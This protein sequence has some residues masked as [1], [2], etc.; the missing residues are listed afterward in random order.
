M[1]KPPPSPRQTTIMRG[2]LRLLPFLLL[3]IIII[4][5]TTQVHADSDGGGAAGLISPL[6]R[7]D[8][9]GRLPQSEAAARAVAK[10]G[11]VIA[12]A[13]AEAVLLVAPWCVL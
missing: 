13:A 1:S 7:F 12:I 11:S 2:P 8:A 9:Q 5:T 6:T 3:S 10:G 4:T